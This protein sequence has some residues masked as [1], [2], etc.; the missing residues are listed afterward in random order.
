MDRM[1]KD[2]EDDFYL[3][4]S[5]PPKKRTHEVTD[6]NKTSDTQGPDV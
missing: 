6:S 1:I 4:Y 5:C 3:K 2:R